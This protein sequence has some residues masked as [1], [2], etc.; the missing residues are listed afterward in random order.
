[1]RIFVNNE[2]LDFKTETEKN[3]G[4][5]LGEVEKFCN[6][7]GHTVYKV[8]VGEDELPLKNLD[9]LFAMPLNSDIELN[10]FTLSIESIKETIGEIAKELQEQA[11]ALIEVGVKLQTNDDR[12]VLD[13]IAKISYNIQVLFE[14]LTLIQVLDTAAYKKLKTP[15]ILEKQKT[16]TE[17]LKDITT[18]LEE[19]DIITVSD[20]SEYELAPL[21]EALVKDLPD[22]TR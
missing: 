14:H 18:A 13:L 8:F 4:E 17:F 7:N 20:L 22:F 3:V 2:S 21:L 5:V 16:I 6:Q 11:Q 12:F 1:M 10:L 19:K 9:T 15:D